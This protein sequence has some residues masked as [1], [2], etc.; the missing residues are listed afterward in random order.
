[1]DVHSYS[2]P[3]Q[4]RVRHLDL[5][6]KIDF[7]EK[8]L[9]GSAAIHFERITAADLFLDTRDLTIQSVE[10][11]DS[12]ELGPA[13]PVFGAPLRIVPAADADWV[14]VHYSTSPA[15]SGL[16]WL[17]APQTAG[18]EHPFLYTQSQ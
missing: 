14:R 8:M 12:F 3:H 11:A 15:A 17:D 5:D 2:R 10:N 7:R 6:L 4:V 18:K 16:Q 9:E 1:M 13:D